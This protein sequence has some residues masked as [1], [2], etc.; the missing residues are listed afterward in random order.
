[1]FLINVAH[2]HRRLWYVEKNTGNAW[3]LP[4]D[5]INGQLTWFG[6]GEV[7]PNGGYL[8]AIEGWSTDSGDG[9]NEWTVFIGSQGDVAVFEGF[10]PSSSGAFN[11]KGVYKIG[12]PLGYRCVRK[13][14]SDLLVLCE[15]GVM[16][17]SSVLAQSRVLLAQPL[18]DIIQQALSDDV[19]T[20]RT[21]FGWEMAL[22]NRYQFL[23]VNVPINYTNK[24]YVMNSVTMA[25]CEFYGYEAHTWERLHEE[26]YFGGDGFVGRAWYGSADDFNDVTQRGQSVPAQCLQAFNT[27]GSPATQKH[28]TMIRPI[29]NAEA[30]PRLTVGMNTD[31]NLLDDS[32]APPP[33]SKDLAPTL[34][35]TNASPH[36]IWD[37]SK[38]SAGLRSFTRWFSVNDIGF[39]GAIYIKIAASNETNWVATHYVVEAGGTL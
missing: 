34:W 23:F 32:G 13:Y 39:A 20:Y 17:M 14:G 11:L 31:Y 21:L 19:T 35:G 33:Q 28:W 30:E 1:V 9:M 22:F 6:V 10:D 27:F 29:F 26:P 36:A 16:A 4:V 24:Q 12:S 3:Y 8:V 7:F 25:W 2:V 37:E 38:W 18:S 15:D 5:Q